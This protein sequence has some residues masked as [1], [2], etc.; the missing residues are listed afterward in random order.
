[1]GDI[2]VQTLRD[3]KLPHAYSA[4]AE[5]VTISVGGATMIPSQGEKPSII[6]EQADQGVY[7][8]KESG[9]NRFVAVGDA[10]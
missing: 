9:R 3:L 8:A 5:F 1:M 2:V 6:I 7:Q 4:A 10:G